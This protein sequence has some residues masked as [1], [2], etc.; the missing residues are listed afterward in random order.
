MR[1]GQLIVAAAIVVATV[2]VGATIASRV[3]AQTRV[4]PATGAPIGATFWLR[5]PCQ[6]A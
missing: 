5:L 4:D 6:P 3:T 1:N 2:G